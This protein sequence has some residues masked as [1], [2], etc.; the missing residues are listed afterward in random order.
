MRKGDSMKIDI[1]DGNE[2][3]WANEKGEIWRKLDGSICVNPSSDW[4]LLGAVRY[5]NFG[6]IVER[7]D[8]SELKNLNGDWQYKNG[9]QKWH[10]MDY[11]HGSKRMWGS[12]NHKVVVD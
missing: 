9:K 2:W 1:L 6:H 11:D 8:F 4:R 10:V 3:M 5:N 12:P 7:A